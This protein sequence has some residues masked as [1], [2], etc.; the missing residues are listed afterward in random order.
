MVLTNTGTD[1]TDPFWA[2]CN[3]GSDE[4]NF[5]E[6][7]KTDLLPTSPALLNWMMI[8]ILMKM[9]RMILMVM[10]MLMMRKI[11]LKPPSLLDWNVAK[12]T[13]ANKSFK[14]H[15]ASQRKM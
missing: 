7:K 2:D 9:V 1:I 4:A 15:T 3:L 11:K 14:D 12:T 6:E 8:L 5:S 10:T 13:K